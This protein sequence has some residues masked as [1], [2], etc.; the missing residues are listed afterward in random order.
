MGNKQSNLFDSGLTSV[1]FVLCYSRIQNTTTSPYFASSVGAD[2][3][4]GLSSIE[5]EDAHGPLSIMGEH[6]WH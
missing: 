1:A 2:V 6:D 4:P 5:P 3:H